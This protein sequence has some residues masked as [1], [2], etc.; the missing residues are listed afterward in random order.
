MPPYHN[1]IKPC[2]L[3]RIPFYL[4]SKNKFQALGV[5]IPRNEC[6]AWQSSGKLLLYILYALMRYRNLDG[7]PPRILRVRLKFAEYSCTWNLMV[8]SK[9]N[10]F[11]V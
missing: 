6:Q 2:K 11:L 5:H 3:A 10:W 9:C 7:Y 4:A 8:A 1:I